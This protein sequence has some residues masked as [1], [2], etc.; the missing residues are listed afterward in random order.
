VVKD[1]DPSA[2]LS[3]LYVELETVTRPLVEIRYGALAAFERCPDDP[4]LKALVDDVTADLM[5]AE[6]LAFGCSGKIILACRY[7]GWRPE[8]VGPILPLVKTEAQTGHK[9]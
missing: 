9:P 4:N 2:C 7:H 8:A 5:A 6:K 1:A 3:R